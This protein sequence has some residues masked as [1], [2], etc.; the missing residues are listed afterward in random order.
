[1]ISKFKPAVKR[2]CLILISGIMWSSVG[3]L[4][5]W[6]ASKWLLEFKQWQIAFTYLVGIS[7]G[8]IIAKFGF[9][10]LAQK[11]NNRIMNYPEKVCVFA[12]QRWQMYFLIAFMMSLGIFMRT[13]SLIPKYLL[14][15]MYVGIGTA[16]FLGSFVYYK[17]L[18]IKKKTI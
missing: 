5:N 15:P 8:I 14:A 2:K 12:F 10:K 4:L 17:T 1:M 16:L 13:S 11:N 7:A 3:I 6:I 9:G 18:F